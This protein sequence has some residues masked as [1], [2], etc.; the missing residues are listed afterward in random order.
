MLIMELYSGRTDFIYNASM[1]AAIPH[2]SCFDHF[3]SSA[4]F[5]MQKL[6]DCLKQFINI[7]NNPHQYKNQ[8]GKTR[9]ESLVIPAGM[10]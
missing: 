3:H 9:Q 1:A 4:S 7:R 10:F 5:T 8:S 2:D 6:L